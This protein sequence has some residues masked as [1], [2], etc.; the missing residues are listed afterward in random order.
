MGCDPVRRVGGTLPSRAAADN[1]RLAWFW[2]EPEKGVA[3]PMEAGTVT[4]TFVPAM[5]SVKAVSLSAEEGASHRTAENSE[6]GLE[7]GFAKRGNPADCW[8]PG[9]VRVRT[10]LICRD[11]IEFKSSVMAV[12]DPGW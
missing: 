7:V 8:K 2:S 12:T 5:I 3:I 1:W 9:R 11:M 6:A 4:V 10:S